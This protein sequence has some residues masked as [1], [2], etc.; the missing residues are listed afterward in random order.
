MRDPLR[1]RHMRDDDDGSGSQAP[2]CDANV[3]GHPAMPHLSLSAADLD[4]PH[5][6]MR[7]PTDDQP[8]DLEHNLGDPIL[9]GG[10]RIASEIRTA[11]LTEGRTRRRDPV[12]LLET[13]LL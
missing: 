5:P 7:A 6:P 13:S 11:M 12:G 1:S 4:R 3:S 8:G 2:Y 9:Q 10:M